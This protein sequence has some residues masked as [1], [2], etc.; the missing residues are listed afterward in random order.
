MRNI[1]YSLLV[2]LSVLAT[3]VF[4]QNP[5][6]DVAG[7]YE[8]NK[9]E[10]VSNL[11]LLEDKTFMFYATFGNVDI[12]CWGNYTIEDD[13]I[14]LQPDTNLMDEF[15]FYGTTNQTE[16]L[17]VYFLVPYGREFTIKAANKVLPPLLEGDSFT[18]VSLPKTN[19]LTITYSS[20]ENPKE[21]TLHVKLP[22]NTDEVRI[23]YNRNASIIRQLTQKTFSTKSGEYA[24][25][26]KKG[27]TE[28]LVKKL[29]LRINRKR[30]F[31]SFIKDE[32]KYEK[33]KLLR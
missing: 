23:L 32:K 28:D 30:T 18:S 14:T 2:V 24:T 26:Y 17:Q 12:E 10:F 1:K 15:E 22:E 6:K 25:K 13:Q 19:Q 7:F 11:F 31:T 29:K 20:L 8:V 27:M 16:S 33:L 21:Q 3:T 5:Y 9:M 4:A